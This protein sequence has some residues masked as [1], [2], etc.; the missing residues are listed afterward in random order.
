MTG[1][2]SGVLLDFGIDG[3]TAGVVSLRE[4]LGPDCA[5][6]KI[7]SHGDI[8]VLYAEDYVPKTL[9][10]VVSQ[11]EDLVGVKGLLPVKSS[12]VK[13]VQTQTLQIESDLP[14]C[15][16]EVAKNPEILKDIYR[17][18]TIEVEMEHAWQEHVCVYGS[19]YYFLFKLEEER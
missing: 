3:E 16:A 7:A 8:F 9:A 5:V 4:D 10:E 14:K 13:P 19:Y 2:L 11:V 17:G 12:Q 6:W 1:D 15:F 18:E